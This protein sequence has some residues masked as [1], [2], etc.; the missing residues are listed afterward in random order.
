M[1]VLGRVQNGV[2]I[3]ENGSALPEGAIVTVSC[4]EPPIK[5][6]T[7]GGTRVDVPLVKTGQPGS[8]DL[9]GERIADILDEEDAAP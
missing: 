4:G 5:T 3:L 6:A 9:S 1:V 8:V 7:P 2:V